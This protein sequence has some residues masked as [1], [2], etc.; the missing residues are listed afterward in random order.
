MKQ[1]FAQR[2]QITVEN[3]PAPLI[4]KGRVL[5]EI[6]Y[7]LIS[8]GTELSVVNSSG[9]T[10]VDKVLEQPERLKKVVEYLRRQGV[11]KTI[12]VVRGQTSEEARPIGYSCSGYVVQ[13]GEGI[14]DLRPGDSVACAGAGMA[15]HAEIVLVPRNLVVKIPEG[16][17]FK[18][19]ASATLGAIALQGIRRADLRLGETV[20][21]VGL[22]LL[23]Q[24]T[25]QLLKA[26]GCRVVGLD[27]DARRVE[28]AGKSGA[29]LAL[30][31]AE[32]SVDNEI[33]H[34]T[35]GHGVDATIITAA[36]QSD[37]LVQQ[38]MEI[39]R[40]KGRVVVVGAVGLGLKRSPFYEKEIDFL[41][42]CSY[43][44]GRYDLAYEEQGQDYPYAYVRWTENRNMQEYLRLIGEGSV[45]LSA[46]LEREYD[47]DRAE[48]AY[49]E[50]NGSKEKPLGV[51]LKYPVLV[52]EEREKKRLTKVV[53]GNKVTSGKVKIAV[54]GAGN[55][56]KTVHLK[57]LK[58]LSDLYHLRAVVSAT[59]YNAKTT[60]QQ[61]G[62]DYGSTDYQDVLN[63]PDVDAVLICT[64]H[65]IHA[66][67]VLQALEAG[68]HV[69]VE[70]PL[71]MNQEELAEI[72]NCSSRNPGLVLLTGFNRR[73]S[74]HI[75]RIKEIVDR[76]KNPMIINYRMNAGY[77]PLDHWVQGPEGGG[78]NIG[79]ACHIYDLFTF[80][81]NAKYAQVITKRI[82]PQTEDFSSQD[83][84][85]C[86][87]SFAEGSVATLTYTA[88]GSKDYP[89]E[90]M[91]IFTD[92]EVIVMEDFKTVEIIGTGERGVKTRVMEKGL[93]EELYSFA[94]ALKGES[95]CPNPLWQQIQAMEIAFASSN[96]C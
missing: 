50:L 82:Q 63:D 52:E 40:K 76:R 20:A 15:N 31:S 79:E 60:A 22:G 8:P 62:A 37:S 94:M 66:P 1:V 61:F 93:K 78:R 69:L 47:L 27:V 84:F 32:V 53:L 45:E 87:V 56:A 73:F 67:M 34:W 29:D 4:D 17:D 58:S 77:I 30:N 70:K 19:A 33:R 2:G 41:I 51:L 83:N 54:V 75:Q 7:S 36:S 11:K 57:N 12:A 39:T 68:K 96:G 21:V 72:Q 48:Q 92:G 49:A 14:T 81:T 42:S 85:V 5:V 16:C 55:F 24:I 10:L 71:A 35:G 43:G 74:P 90:K 28:L 23:G 89:K 44:P 13:V 59:G 65:N 38:A 88:L 91:E 6:V 46:I 18:S 3:V 9:K 86:T 95:S 64:R 80:L 26:S 25:V